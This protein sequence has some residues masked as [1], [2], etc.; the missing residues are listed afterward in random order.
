MVKVY[1]AIDVSVC[2]KCYDR[3]RHRSLW[4]SRK[5]KLTLALEKAS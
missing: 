5:E 2:G 4:E 1:R 3:G